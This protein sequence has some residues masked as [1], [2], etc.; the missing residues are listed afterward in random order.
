MQKKLHKTL[1]KNE[2]NI[3]NMELT[4]SES[5]NYSNIPLSSPEKKRPNVVLIVLDTARKDS[6]GVHNS[7]QRTPNIDSFA[8]DAYVFDNA[9]APSS[10]TLP[11]HISMFTGLYPE[12]HGIHAQTMT[13]SSY[14]I[15][16][17]S[18]RN[19]TRFLRDYGYSTHGISANLIVSEEFHFDSGFEHFQC[20]N[21][22]HDVKMPERFKR[23]MLEKE[24][25]KFDPIALI[26]S[27]VWAWKGKR[28][29]KQNGFPRVKAGDR[30]AEEASKIQGKRPFYMFLNFMEMHEPYLPASVRVTPFI[31]IRGKSLWYGQWS[32][33]EN[34]VRDF[35]G[36]S[37]LKSSMKDRIKRLYFKQAEYAD[38]YVGRV[39]NDLKRKGL[40]DNSLIIITSDHGQSLKEKDHRWLYHM[41]YLYDEL[42]RVPLMVKYPKSKKEE[43][44]GTRIEENIS[45]VSIHDMI[46]DFVKTGSRDPYRFTSKV[47][48]S[49]AF[50]VNTL[51][52]YRKFSNLFKKESEAFNRLSSLRKAVFKNGYK[53]VVNG[54]HGTIEEFTLHGESLSETD[55]AINDLLDE[56]EVFCGIDDFRFPE[57]IES[58]VPVKLTINV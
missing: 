19:I 37:K 11:S 4:E 17:E 51:L 15:L 43:Y 12:E 49:E 23:R 7:N 39:L 42:I 32:P 35:F 18:E 20:V 44:R 5:V 9:I 56:L 41:H 33:M 58:R 45:T 10:W 54:T 57:R 8:K 48:F 47:V 28:N 3:K 16:R 26:E 46:E 34:Q 13:S 25:K 29:K 38:R 40:Y 1:I 22:K 53:M 50:G 52:N 36:I 31:E 24:K 21:Y 14:S 2:V 6:L 27:I 55:E 30:I